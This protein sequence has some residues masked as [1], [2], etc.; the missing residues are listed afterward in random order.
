MK[1]LTSIFLLFLFYSQLIFAE[2]FY[3]LLG[4]SR[5]ANNRQIRQAF[6]KLA[7]TLHPDKNKDDPDANE[8][9]MKINKAYEVL[10]DEE[11]RK[12]Y[13]VHGE[14]E[15]NSQRGGNYHSWNY[16]Y[17]NFGIYDDDQE[18]ITLS[19]TDFEQSVT[20]TRDVWFVNFYSGSCSHCHHLAPE[21]RHVARELE[22]VIRI[23][24]VNC[25]EDWLLCRQENVNSYPL[26][27]LY[28]RGVK[29]QGARDRVS[30]VKF[31]LNELSTHVL[32]M[33]EDNYDDYRDKSELPWLISFCFDQDVCV[34]SETL[35]KLSAML[36]GLVHVATTDCIQ[37]T[38][39]CSNFDQHESRIVYFHSLKD[40]KHDEIPSNDAQDIYKTVLGF[41]PD[42]I[43]LDN[44]KFNDIYKQLSTHGGKPWLVEFIVDS[45]TDLQLRKLPSLLPDVGRVDCAKASLV[46]QT[47]YVRKYPTFILFKADGTHEIHHGRQSP[48]DVAVF[49]QECRQSAVVTLGPNDF[50][51]R[52]VDDGD[53]WFVDFYAPWCPPCMRLLPEW[54]KASRS[55]ESGIHFGT[56]D[57]T[58]HQSLCQKYNIH[59]YPTSILY[60]RSVPH[61]YFG[62]PSA[63]AIVEFIQ[64]IRFPPV[65][66][67]TF[68]T[69]ES[70]VNNRRTSD[71]WLVDFFAPWCQPCQQL[72]PEWRQLAKM[73]F[74]MENIHIGQ[75]D[76]TT[77]S[78]LCQQQNVR[79]YPTIRLYPI[80][81]AGSS[82]FHLYNGWGRDAHSIRAWALHFLPSNVDELNFETFSRVLIGEKPVAI[83]FYAPWCGHCQ[84]FAPEFDAIA[85]NFED[86]IY[87][88]K[89]N[90]EK[91][92]DICRKA[93]IRAYPT[94][95][96][97]PVPNTKND[98]IGEDI[99]SQHA[100]TITNILQ[101]KLERLKQI[102]HEEHDEL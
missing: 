26:L 102:K 39:I 56:V 37:Q 14:E 20:G 13:D 34:T 50:P 15:F 88:G 72:A 61:Q 97:Y 2:D 66:V 9:F 28:P 33:R 76:C 83:D 12:K 30:L 67:L 29:Y 45:Q 11:L 60:N 31:V 68:Q 38:V 47:F 55:V 24:A 71:M 25:E 74:K 95:R 44:D 93:N 22:G 41:L 40:G 82:H 27:M 85:K 51:E 3:Q 99:N 62:K 42:M 75:V 53:T 78:M 70:L 64:D 57:C 59:S 43:S 6:K 7:L 18:I 77:E 94:V 10:K 65:V 96:F 98:M 81:E 100:E 92:P 17:E 36:D 5:D 86:K 19:R 101:T 90:C 16:Y 79:A 8:K 46:C 80:D 4:I 91:H 1:T 52:V 54:R 23:G 35:E 49:V 21:W 87:F 32:E 69:F 73:V 48:Q 63:P 89:V 58:I 84:T